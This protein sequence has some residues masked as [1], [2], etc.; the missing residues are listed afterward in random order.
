MKRTLAVVALVLGLVLA[1]VSAVAAGGL[2]G[3]SV[4]IGGSRVMTTAGPG[5]PIWPR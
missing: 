1:S 5:C 4:A 2:S 3:E